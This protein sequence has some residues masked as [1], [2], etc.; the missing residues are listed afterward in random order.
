[1]EHLRRY[2]FVLIS[3]LI[4]ISTSLAEEVL[5]SI[6]PGNIPYL[7][8]GRV[9]ASWRLKGGGSP[10]EG[11]NIYFFGI[12]VAEYYKKPIESVS[13]ADLI[14]VFGSK[15]NDPS[16]WY[17][18]VVSFSHE[19]H[20]PYRDYNNYIEGELKRLIIEEF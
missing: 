20:D 1:M 17:L 5:F 12:V 6:E 14:S 4:W 7:K 16:T 11:I 15:Y 18:K 3:V 19:I 2:L 10:P 8:E 13:E 9:Y